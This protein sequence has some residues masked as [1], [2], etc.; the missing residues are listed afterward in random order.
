MYKSYAD[1]IET[2]ND[3][4]ETPEGKH[5]DQYEVTEIRDIQHKREILANNAIVCVDIYA[6][7]CGPCKQTAPD[8]AMLSQRYSHPGICAVVKEL[9][10]KKLTNPPPGGLPT[11]QF[12]YMGKKVG[13]DIIG[14]DLASV[15]KRLE[16]YAKTINSFRGTDQNQGRQQNQPSQYSQLQHN[17]YGP[18]GPPQGPP[19]GPVS[20]SQQGAGQGYQGQQESQ[21]QGG[22][23]ANRSSIRAYRPGQGSYNNQG[24]PGS[25]NYS[26]GPMY[27]QG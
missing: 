18:R 6:D 9:Y 16:Q 4:P 21:N 10:E 3:G 19:S 2:K 12:F 7:W 24:Y 15:E 11:Y 25:D 14:A 8:Y 13:E 1:L 23:Q 5:I 17:G 27:H 22:P 26:R 20:G